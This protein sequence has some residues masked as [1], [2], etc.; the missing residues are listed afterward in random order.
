MYQN[1]N[2]KRKLILEEADDKLMF[3]KP[4]MQCQMA[5]G[6]IGRLADVL[7]EKLLLKQWICQ[8]SVQ[9]VSS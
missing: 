7:F 5:E 9:H 8:I 1:R 2:T 3:G 4:T 6:Q